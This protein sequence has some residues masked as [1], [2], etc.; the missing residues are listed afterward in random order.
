MGFRSGDIETLLNWEI[1]MC[2]AASNRPQRNEKMQ[3]T[4]VHLPSDLLYMLRMVAVTRARR[5]G[6]RP[7]VSDVIREMIESNRRQFHEEAF[8]STSH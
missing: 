3:V 5:S 4:S 2:A 6:G 7:S 1:P 8:G